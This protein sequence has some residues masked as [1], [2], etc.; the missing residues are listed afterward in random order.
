MTS[1]A[2]RTDPPKTAPSPNATPTPFG[3]GFT[4]SGPK[5]AIK[6]AGCLTCLSAHAGLCCH[7]PPHAAFTPGCGVCLAAQKQLCPVHGIGAVKALDTYGASLSG[8]EAKAFASTRAF[9]AEQLAQIPDTAWVKIDIGGDA[10]KHID[11]DGG[12]TGVPLY[13]SRIVVTATVTG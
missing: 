6:V 8:Q 10:G 13:A 3:W 7:Q 1:P 11:A 4:Y 12:P 9:V 5:N 2:P